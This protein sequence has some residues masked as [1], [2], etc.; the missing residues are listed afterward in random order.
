M[1]SFGTNGMLFA[2]VGSSARGRPLAFRGWGCCVGRHWVPDRTFLRS[3]CHCHSLNRFNFRL[4][5]SGLENSVVPQASNNRHRDALKL[6]EAYKQS[7]QETTHHIRKK[8]REE[9]LQQRRMA[10]PNRMIRFDQFQPTPQAIV[11]AF[12]ERVHKVQQQGLGPSR[13]LVSEIR[14]VRR[15]IQMTDPVQLEAFT[16][17]FFEQG[18]QHALVQIFRYSEMVND[19]VIQEAAWIL[20][21]VSS[22]SPHFLRALMYI[23]I[24]LVLGPFVTHESAA[25]RQQV[26]WLLGNMAKAGHEFRD[27]VFNNQDIVQGLLQ[28]LEAPMDEEVLKTCLWTI[29]N[30]LQ[31]TPQPSSQLTQLFVPHVLTLFNAEVEQGGRPEVLSALLNCV[32]QLAKCEVTVLESMF[33][34]QKG[35]LSRTL[36]QFAKKFGYGHP[37]LLLSVAAILVLL[38]SVDAAYAQQIVAAGLL[39]EECLSKFL[40][41]R[42]VSL[43]VV[44]ARNVCRAR[45]AMRIL[46]MAR[47]H[48][49]PTELP[50]CQNVG[51]TRHYRCRC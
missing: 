35:I 15:V 22:R 20:S 7:R 51:I 43:T 18:G 27:H 25:S 42:Q 37:S 48:P 44:S 24:V 49:A 10:P 12:V 5:V 47:F 45:S 11:H 50:G 21:N 9:R 19:D 23:G 32:L 30:C 13:Q 14:D 34:E 17:L 41:L 26:V 28:N 46:Y 2:V 36:V 3:M 4:H 33:R 31:I 29:A 40:V 38:S 39:E 16:N 6:R 1:S 8:K